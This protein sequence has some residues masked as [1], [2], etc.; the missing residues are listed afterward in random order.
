MVKFMFCNQCGIKL[1][2]D[3]KVCPNCG[4]PSSTDMISASLQNRQITK[5]FI[6]KKSTNWKFIIRFFII[7]T[8]YVT[9]ITVVF[10]YTQLKNIHNNNSVQSVQHINR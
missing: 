1:S 6:E 3:N 7:F 4:L 9:V 2:V 5:K 8:I 10:T